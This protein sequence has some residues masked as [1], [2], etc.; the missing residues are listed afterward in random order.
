MIVKKPVKY[1]YNYRQGS[2]LVA[3]MSALSVAWGRP[4]PRR[5]SIYELDAKEK[6]WLGGDRHHARLASAPKTSSTSGHQR[7][8]G[9]VGTNYHH[10]VVVPGIQA[11][12]PRN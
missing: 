10:V 1:S 7:L 3:F 9:V 2:H 8:G 4:S 11:V 6:A 5:L 12:R